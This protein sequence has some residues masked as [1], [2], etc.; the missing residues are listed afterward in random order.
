MLLILIDKILPLS[1]YRFLWEQFQNLRVLI[2]LSGP[3]FLPKSIIIRHKIKLSI[4]TVNMTG[5]SVYKDAVYI[6]AAMRRYSFCILGIQ[7]KKKLVTI[8]IFRQI[9]LNQLITFRVQISF[10]TVKSLSEIRTWCYRFSCLS[11]ICWVSPKKTLW[12]Q[13]SSRVFG[14]LL[15]WR[16]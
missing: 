6:L 16:L 5:V 2:L 11:V 12:E 7:V 4:D 3:I 14:K 9:I 8:A 1:F 13:L 10:N 15:N